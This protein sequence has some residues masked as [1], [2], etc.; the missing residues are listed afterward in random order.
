M[1]V[2]KILYRDILESITKFLVSLGHSMIRT[3]SLEER[4]STCNGRPDKQNYE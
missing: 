3:F 1:L 4:K 2:N